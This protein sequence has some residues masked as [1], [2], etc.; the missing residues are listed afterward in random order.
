M[1]EVWIERPPIAASGGA[2]PYALRSE[3]VVARAIAVRLRPTSGRYVIDAG[4]PETQWDQ[5]GAAGSDRLASESAVWRFIVTPLQSGRGSLQ[6]AVSARTLGADGVLAESQL[7]DQQH[8]VR[9][10][11]SYGGLLRRFVTT[12]GA[13]ILGMVIIKLIEGQIGVDLY[14]TAKQLLRSLS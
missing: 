1:I 13:M 12:I 6:L 8:I 10:A 7:P 14:Y 3:S 4:S 9:I 11:P 5:S 2:R